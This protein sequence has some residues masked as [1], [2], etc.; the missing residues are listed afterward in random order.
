[1]RVVADDY[2]AKAPFINWKLGSRMAPLRWID[3]VALLCPAVP[4]G[5]FVAAFALSAAAVF[6]SMSSIMAL[7]A[8]GGQ[9]VV[10]LLLLWSCC[11]RLLLL[12]RKGSAAMLL[13]GGALLYGSS[14]AVSVLFWMVELW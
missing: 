10:V 8:F 6:P 7:A 9:A 1:M 3:I 13:A 12:N 14:I 5:G 11:R 2:F 4:M